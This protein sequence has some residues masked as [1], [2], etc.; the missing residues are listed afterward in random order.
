MKFGG[1]N[2]LGPQKEYFLGIEWTVA[3]ARNMTDAGIV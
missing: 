3:E 1:N 2:N